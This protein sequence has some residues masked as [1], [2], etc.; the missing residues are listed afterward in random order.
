[1]ELKMSNKYDL[2]IIG[3][4][5]AGYT[6]AIYASRYNLSTLIIGAELG[7]TASKAPEIQNYPPYQSITGLELMELFEKHVRSLGV[8]IKVANVLEI[9]G[10]DQ[11]FKVITEDETFFSKKIL[12][13]TGS[14]SKKSDIKNED[15]FIGK[16]VSYCTTCDAPLF[17]ERIVAV[18]GGG[19]SALQSALLLSQFAKKVYLIHRKEN[20]DKAEPNLINKIKK[21]KNVEILLNKEVIS[22]EGDKFVKKVVLKDKTEIN[23]DGFFI[24]T[25]YIPRN[26]LTK[27]LG[28]NLDERGYI[29]VDENQKT[30][31]P[32]VYAA[33]DCTYRKYKQI[34]TAASEGAIAIMA[35][36][37]EFQKENA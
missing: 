21:L 14:Q 8:N 15:K 26:E 22:V 1:M 6:A 11:N 23:V 25:G 31:V 10:N 16:G 36:Y 35:L 5:P 13:A 18:L 2:I 4:G 17:K 34:I 27:N 32:G 30:N 20:F 3:T 9:L 28:I 33:G 19:N 24:M 37:K 12:L 29:I 7:G